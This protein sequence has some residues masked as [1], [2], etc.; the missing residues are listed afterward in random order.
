MLPTTA[1]D[2]TTPSICTVGSASAVTPVDDRCTGGVGLA[3]AG[4]ARASTTAPISAATLAADIP[5]SESG[6]LLIVIP[7]VNLFLDYDRFPQRDEKHTDLERRPGCALGAD[8][9][10]NLTVAS[11]LPLCALW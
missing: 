9:Q 11:D 1:C 8:G 5:R 7:R 6:R 2:Q 3:H 10:H 4:V